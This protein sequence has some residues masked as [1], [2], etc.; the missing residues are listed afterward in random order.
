MD[1][2]DVLTQQ[3]STLMQMLSSMMAACIEAVPGCTDSAATNYNADANTDDGS[4][5]YCTG[6]F[7][8]YTSNTVSDYNNVAISALLNGSSSTTPL[9]NS[10]G[11]K[12]GSW[13]ADNNGMVGSDLGISDDNRV[14]SYL[15]SSTF[16]NVFQGIPSQ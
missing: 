3:Q 11:M 16:Q 14:S 12:F 1:S 9:I 15:P 5:E 8:S 6:Y 2:L 7:Q 13:V 4:C 10:A